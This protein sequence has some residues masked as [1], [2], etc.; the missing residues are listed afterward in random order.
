LIL[1]PKIESSHPFTLSH[2]LVATG[3]AQWLDPD[4]MEDLTYSMFLRNL[5][6]YGQPA[7]LSQ[8]AAR[9]ELIWDYLVEDV[10]RNLW[11]L[12]M[13][14]DDNAAILEESENDLS[15]L[16]VKRLAKQKLL[17]DCEGEVINFRKVSGYDTYS[18]QLAKEEVEFRK[19]YEDLLS[20]FLEENS[21]RLC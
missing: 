1:K 13:K 10:P 21:K 16:D 7:P 2:A 15:P 6:P 17:V 8:I 20:K 19:E 11:T 5:V 12:E 9:G 18:I 4:L 3:Q 14:K